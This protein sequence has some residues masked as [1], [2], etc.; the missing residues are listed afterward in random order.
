MT[1]DAAADAPALPRS[2]RAVYSLILGLAPF[3]FN[4]VL[5]LS[6]RAI[7]GPPEL[8]TVDAAAVVVVIAGVQLVLGAVAVSLAIVF[9]FRAL[10]EIREGRARGRI[11][12]RFGIAL[13]IFNG[14]L[15]LLSFLG[16]LYTPIG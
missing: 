11:M 7:F 15:I 2:R 16:A 1:D 9:G 10:K 8:V 6:I 14:A 13:G 5:N 3:L 4:M 12:A